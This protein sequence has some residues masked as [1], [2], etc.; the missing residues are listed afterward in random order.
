MIDVITLKGVVPKIFGHS[1]TWKSDVWLADLQFVKGSRYLVEAASGRGKTSLCSFIM[2]M[3]SDYDGS[4]L[5]DGR[6]TGNFNSSE[7]SRLRRNALAWMPQ[8]LGLFPQLTLA[9]NIAIKNRLTNHLDSQRIETLVRRLGLFEKMNTK[10]SLL[11]IGQQQRGAFIRMLCQ[12]ADFYL[13]DEPVSHLD[14]ENNKL[15]SEI[16]EQE[17]ERTGSGVIVTSVGNR[18]AL[19]NLQRITL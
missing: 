11:S 9:E 12:P 14:A 19:D 3:R 15:L 13:L 2:G 4:I 10:A 1:L 8:E 5:F 17:L 7:W 16:L 18:L 6:D